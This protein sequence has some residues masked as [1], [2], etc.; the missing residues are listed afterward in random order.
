MLPLLLVI[1]SDRTTSEPF[2][3]EISASGFK[4]YYVETLTSALGVMGQWHFDA[5]LLHAHGFDGALAH[6]LAS[7]RRDAGVPILLVAPGADEDEQLQALD[8]GA[9][10]VVAE[11]STR[12]VAAQLRRLIDVSHPRQPQESSEVRFGS[13][14]LDPRRAAA[15]VGNAPVALTAGEFEVLL[16]LASRPGQLVH[17][18]TIARTLGRADGADTRRSADMH[19]CR[20]RR[21]LR[22]AGGA[23][24][25]VETVY[26]RGY[27]LRQRAEPVEREAARVAEWFV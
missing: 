16:L 14:R 21:K 19:I 4:A 6:M 24:L 2:R 8:A 10:Q 17:R 12:V 15:S 3:H 13:L 5:V 11:A 26:G 7:L 22:D 27:L 20:I 18:Q 1:T 25:Q 23:S 9:S